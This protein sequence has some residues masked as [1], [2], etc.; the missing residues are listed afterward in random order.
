MYMLHIIC[1]QTFLIYFIFYLILTL[2]TYFYFSDSIMV[3][4]DINSNVITL[5][6]GYDDPPGP[7]QQDIIV[8]GWYMSRRYSMI[9]INTFG[10]TTTELLYIHNVTPFLF[11]LY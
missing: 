8:T 3:D 1:E 9:I 11:I 6:S 4:V 5:L 7:S 2:T 10:C